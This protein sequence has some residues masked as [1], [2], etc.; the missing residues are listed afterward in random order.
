MNS[1][2]TKLCVADFDDVPQRALAGLAGQQ[3]QEGAEI[4]A[5]EFLERRELP[6]DRAELVAELEDAALE[7]PV[8]APRPPRR[9]CGC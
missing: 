4:V 8:D 6:E 5:V 7:E 2:T 3:V 1:G 9:A